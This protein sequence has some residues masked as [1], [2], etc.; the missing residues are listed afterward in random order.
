MR[1]CVRDVHVCVH[2]CVHVCVHVCVRVCVC[3]RGCVNIGVCWHWM[4]II[5]QR[6]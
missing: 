5:V 1:A 3:V 4:L 2:A 6:N